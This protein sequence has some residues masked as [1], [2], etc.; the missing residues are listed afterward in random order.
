MGRAFCLVEVWDQLDLTR[1]RINVDDGVVIKR[2]VVIKSNQS[3]VLP[4]S[5]HLIHV[6]NITELR[7]IKKGHEECPLWARSL[8]LNPVHHAYRADFVRQRAS[9]SPLLSPTRAHVGEVLTVVPLFVLAAV[10][11]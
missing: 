7:T 2:V 5:R 10:E 8:H 6:M 4:H 1:N 9:F 11:G 3:R